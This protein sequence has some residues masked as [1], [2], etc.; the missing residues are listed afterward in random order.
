MFIVF[1]IYNVNE[2]VMLV[3]QMIKYGKVEYYV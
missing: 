1:L 2:L 3:N